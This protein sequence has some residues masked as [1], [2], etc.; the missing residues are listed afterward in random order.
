M[1][2]CIKY[3]KICESKTLKNQTLRNLKATRRKDKL[4]SKE[5]QTDS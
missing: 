1:Y 3:T 4:S 2:V 5:R